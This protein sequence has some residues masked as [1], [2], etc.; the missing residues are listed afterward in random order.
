MKFYLLRSL[1]SDEDLIAIFTR[2]W[3]IKIQRN[4]TDFEFYAQLF[5]QCLRFVTSSE[6][7]HMPQS[8]LSGNLRW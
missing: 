2:E 6:V 3:P 5:A 4:E 1:S 8:P 7:L